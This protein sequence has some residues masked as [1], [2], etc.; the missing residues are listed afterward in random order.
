MTKKSKFY[1]IIPKENKSIRNIPIPEKGSN[2]EY[3]GSNEIQIGSE[4]I[5]KHRHSHHKSENHTE[6]SDPKG[7][8][9]K[10]DHKESSSVEIKKLE[11][12]ITN[13]REYD[14]DEYIE[15]VDHMTEDNETVE[16]I[17]LLGENKE[18]IEKTK[19]PSLAETENDDFSDYTKKITGGNRGRNKN[20]FKGLLKGSYKLP[21]SIFILLI[22]CFLGFGL[23]SSAKIIIKTADLNVPLG[24]GYSFAAGDG[25][26]LQSTSTDSVSVP[27]TGTVRLEKKSSGTVVIFNNTTASQKL[28]KGTKMQTLSG[29]VYV[30]D[31]AVVV[32]AKKTVS[33]KVVL[34][35]V[36]TT[37]SAEAVGE[38]YNSDPKDFTFIGFKGISK[39]S[40][41]YG[42]SKGAIDG[43][44]SGDVPN[45]SQ[46]D[47]SAQIADA[48]DKMKITLLALLKK[49]ADSSGLIVNNSNLVYKII[50]SEARLSDDKKQAVVKIDGTIQAETLVNASMAE[51]SKTILGAEDSNGF[52]YKVNLASSTI[53]VSN[54]TSTSSGQITAMGNVGITVFIDKVELAKSLQNKSKKEA[55]ALLQQT[56][57]VTFAQISVS[58]FWKMSLP[59]AEGITVL[60]QD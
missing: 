46:K 19:I 57:G 45:I 13:V 41:I 43:G 35:N 44:Y 33:K 37:F 48:K 21:V 15:I 23:F 11:R 55:L 53:D 4:M 50:N 30:L 20:I 38:K 10:S 14:E 34:G 22:V 24:S 18:E 17:H 3:L 58:P 1:D 40:T 27:A 25:E 12:P 8:V 28:T 32:P 60:V 16:E 49:Q 5:K 6:G 47:L 52:K 51:A 2:G 9:K 42:R 26:V 36:T 29:L 59:K 54:S 56:K 39:Y 7:N 31:S